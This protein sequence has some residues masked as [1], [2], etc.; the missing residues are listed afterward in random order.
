MPF[1]TRRMA[2]GMR[3]TACCRFQLQSKEDGLTALRANLSSGWCRVD[4]GEILNSRLL[5]R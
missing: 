5:Y 1:V 3:G 4:R 2:I